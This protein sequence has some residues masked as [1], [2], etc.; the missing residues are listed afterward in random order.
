MKSFLI[1]VTTLF[2]SFVCTSFLPLP[3][4]TPQN[5]EAGRRYVPNDA[6]G[7]GEKLEYRVG[8]KFITAGSAYFYVRPQPVMRNNQKCYD[9]RFEVR[10]LKSLDWLY[11]VQ[12]GY[13]TLLD[14]D[15]IFPHEFEQHVREGGYSRDFKAQFDQVNNIARANDKEYQIPPFVHDIVSAFYFIRTHDLK[16]KRK[17]DVIQLQNFFDDKT[18]D[19]AIRILGRQEIEVGAGT[20]KC[21][22][23]E[24][25]IVEG[26]LFKSDGRI[27]IWL[28]D[29]DR[30]IPV[31]VSAKI[32]IGTIDSELTSY[33]GLRGNLDAR[34]SD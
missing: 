25:V 18:N 5:V 32:P 19:L 26:G 22:V 23:I 21:I 3:P 24:P 9:I 7:F 30:K 4:L 8:Y 17:G 33:S 34:I 11:K 1:C 20:F 6:F 12:D 14:V 31:K 10:S 2:V 15:G 29:D 27:M 28:S 16:S 13:Q